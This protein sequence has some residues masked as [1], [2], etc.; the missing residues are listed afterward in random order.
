MNAPARLTVGL[1]AIA[2][3]AM[4]L[5]LVLSGVVGSSRFPLRTLRVEGQVTREH[6]LE[7][8]RALAPHAKKGFFAIRVPET[9]QDVARLPW[10][11]KVEVRKRWP[12]VIEVQI[13]ENNPFAFWGKDQLVSTRGTLY[14]RSKG[15]ALPKGMP[16]L[17]GDPRYVGAALALYAKSQDLFAATGNRVRA[18]N[19]D[20]RGS[21]SL[22]LQNGVQVVVGRHDAESRIARFAGILPK[23]AAEQPNRVLERADLRYTNGFALRWGSQV[24]P[25]EKTQ[26]PA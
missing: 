1:I 10:I 14:P 3:I 4:P 5:L 24:K 9:Q 26:D 11:D 18:L 25:T 21:W 15:I 22:T 13:T 20:A 6:A 12:D 7:L 16:Q 17:D 2:L 23:L 8:Q 19:A